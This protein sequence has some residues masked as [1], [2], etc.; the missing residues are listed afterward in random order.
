MSDESAARPTSESST[1]EAP[2]L[3]RALGPGMAIAIVVGNVIGSGIFAKPGRI[4][5]EAGRFDLIIAVWIVGGVLCLLGALCFAE[6]ATM[7]PHAGGLY[8]YL[9]E[10]YGKLTAFLF[11]WQEFL[12]NRPASTAALS[13]IFV[14]SLDI[15]LKGVEFNL[16][17]TLGLAIGLQLAAAAINVVGVLWGGTVQAVTTVI[18]AG[19]VGFVAVLPFVLELG[20]RDVVDVANFSATIVPT[21]ES[22]STQIAAVL[23]A[24]MWAYNGWHGIAPV[25]EEIRN[26]QRNIPIALFGGVGLLIL[27]YLGANIAYHA[28]VPMSEMAVLKNQEHVAEIMVTRLLGDW[29]GKLMAIGVMVSTLGA[30]NSNLLLGPRVPFAMGRDKV[31]FPILGEVHAQF[32]T[33]AVAILVQGSLGVVLVLAS[34]VL[35]EYVDYFKEKSIFSILTDCIIFVSSIF[36]ALSVGAV[37]VLRRKQPDTVRPYR[38][39]GYPFT[40]ILY[41]VVYAW[42]LVYVFLGNPVEALIGL[43]MIAAGVPVFWWWNRNPVKS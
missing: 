1:P 6:L 18:K 26:P 38:T 31:F 17:E 28:V 24:V 13:M 5:A 21:Q 25:A 34:A 9:R 36:Y 2:S 20:G 23:L 10:A 40:P 29:G 11:G 39:L 4:A 33:P 35:V 43:G 12:F 16:F 41:M 42:F 15:A 30:I 22:L 32:R 37:I 7:L 14:G 3:L 19:F 8:V 27:L